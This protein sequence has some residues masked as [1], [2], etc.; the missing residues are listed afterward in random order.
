MYSAHIHNLSLTFVRAPRL[1]SCNENSPTFLLDR[2]GDARLPSLFQKTKLTSKKSKTTKV[3]QYNRDIIC[4][5]SHYA[6][7]GSKSVQIPRGKQRAQLADMGLQGKVTLTSEMSEEAIRAEI[8][9]A[10]MEA[11]END[12]SF[13]FTFLQLSGSGTKIFLYLL[14]HLHF[15]GMHRKF[16]NL[17][18]LVYTS[19]PKRNSL[20]R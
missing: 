15:V 11:M 5:P 7:G 13:P 3:V 9:S 1:Q 16:V 20:L 8:R 19:W 12:P 4:L 18:R 2:A 10:F 6:Q 17:G 14:S